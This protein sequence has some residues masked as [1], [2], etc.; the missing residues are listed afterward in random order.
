MG[1]LG[2]VHVWAR[3]DD[4]S[5][6][7]SLK[8]LE[9]EIPAGHPAGRTQRPESHRVGAYSHAPR[10]HEAI[11]HDTFV[12]DSVRFDRATASPLRLAPLPDARGGPPGRASRSNDQRGDDHMQ[13]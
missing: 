8:Q 3:G 9:E 2:A 5:G 4:A 1:D 12:H 10:R 7:E 11:S 6:E 13:P